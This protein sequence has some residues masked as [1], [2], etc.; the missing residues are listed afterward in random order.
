[1]SK[2]SCTTLVVALLSCLFV[3]NVAAETTFSF[4]DLSS[5]SEL[6]FSAVTDDSSLCSYQSL[7]LATLTSTGDQ[8]AVKSPELL[9]C[10]PQQMNVYKNGGLLEIRNNAGTAMYDS[11]TASLAWTEGSDLASQ[12]R[13]TSSS[14]LEPVS[15][16]PDGNWKC[17][18]EK[19]SAVTANVWL[20]NVNN[21]RKLLLADNAEYR[22][23]SLP[24]L[25]SPDSSVLIYEK[26]GMLYFLRMADALE[27]AALTEE[28]RII[29]K[30]T[31]KNAAWAN[32]KT[33]VYVSYDI[34][35]SIAVNELQTRALYSDFLGIDKIAG[36][37]PVPFDS[38]KDTFWVNNDVTSLVVVQ[39][40][41]TLWYLE[42]TGTDFNYVSTIMSFPLMNVS[43]AAISF[44]V[45]W[46]QTQD[47]GELPI[48]WIEVFRSG[49][50]ESYA[51]R[52]TRHEV[53]NSCSFSPLP[54]LLAVSDPKLSPDGTK[55]AFKS[56]MN[57]HVYDI[58]SWK[59][60][61]VY[62]GEEIISYEWYSVSSLYVGGDETVQ[63]WNI[64][65]DT[66]DIL[67]LSSVDRFGWNMTG[68]IILG[69]NKA[70]TFIFDRERKI[71][72]ATD[73]EITRGVSVQ[74]KKWRV[75]FSESKADNFK[76]GIY[77]RT[78]TG[79]TE[80]RPLITDYV[81]SNDTLP[82]VALVFDALENADGLTTILDTLE[83]SC[84]KATFFINGEFLRR[85][86][87]AS[88]E[89]VNAGHQCASM[90]FTTG[91]LTSFTFVADESYIRR[92]LARNE[93][94]F[95]T[96]T[97]EEL[98]LYWHAPYYDVTDDIRN[99][100][101][102]AGYVYVESDYALKDTST[103]EDYVREGNTY[104]PTK[105]IIADITSSLKD[106]SVISVSTG[107]S[108]GT[109]T[110]YLYDRLDV[111]IS[112]IQEA[113]YRIVPVSEL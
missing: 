21:G 28:F 103:I 83:K 36:R 71:W 16:S 82:R 102:K 62:S 43:G 96:L 52:L 77:V 73:T 58:G 59:Q 57:L 95:F 47:E 8:A 3:M 2:K 22:F 107:V 39:N 112:A 48:V 97:G 67:F 92:G 17:I 10:F 49:E 105:Q 70:G 45:F 91:N 76:N 86:P 13:R 12:T 18:F 72:D 78:L 40:E 109:R 61:D 31:I 25:W 113:G 65:T 20:Q 100:G 53:D 79:L 66:N 44:R 11:A 101:K 108:A 4:M 26:G 94:E 104:Y 87:N 54:M 69:K 19:T 29:G 35:Y 15:V 7:Y 50:R 64:D 93:D 14:F 5:D 74:N 56:D 27:T 23:D 110:D 55:L 63:R 30:G 68:D 38:E 34:V 33:I 88:Q 98:T 84:I 9:T 80:T 111:L 89:I 37:L 1:M 51:Y 41:R 85:F 106:G 6:L 81:V 99:Y 90:F 42:L 32:S 75:F 46:S 24:V 60:T